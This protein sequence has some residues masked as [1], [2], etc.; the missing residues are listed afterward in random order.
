M[1]VLLDTN[2]LVALASS[3]HEYHAATY[4]D[5]KRRRTLGHQFIVSAHGITEAYAVLTR[6]PQPHR[7]TPSAALEVL[8]RTWGK[9]ETVALTAGELWRLL[10][11]CS[12]AAIGGG[13]IYDRVIAECA[14]KGKATEILTWN[15]RHF[16][17]GGIP[18]VSPAMP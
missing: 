13:R 7:L 12:A 8:D 4:T 14:R 9:T 15:T 18:A 10:R 5:Y 17:G 11:T 6:L 16:D 2:C 1:R 3:E